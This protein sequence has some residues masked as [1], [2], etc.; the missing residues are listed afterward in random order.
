ML[1]Q[2]SRNPSPHCHIRNNMS[3]RFI[4]P[5]KHESKKWFI[6]DGI[7]SSF[8]RT[9]SCAQDW[10]E[11]QEWINNHAGYKFGW[12]SYAAGN[13][14][15]GVQLEADNRDSFP[16]L[17]FF[18]PKNLI[19]TDGQSWHVIS[20]QI[21]DQ[22]TEC[23]DL[24]SA[25]QEETIQLSPEISREDYL[26]AVV[27]LKKHIQQGDIYEVNFCQIF[28]A[29]KTINHP[30]NLWKRLYNLTEA[31]H[32]VYAQYKQWHLLSASPERYI[33]KR[34]S[35]VFSQPIKGTIRRGQSTAEDEKL[36]NDIYK[37][38]K[39]RSENV[40]IVDL[41]R[42]DMSHFAQKGTV[43]VDELFGVHTFKTVHHLVSTISC[44]VSQKVSFTDI[45]MASFPMGSMT[46]APKRS[47]MQLIR[48]FEKSSRGLYSGS[49][50]Y[51]TPEGDFD[52]N[53]VIRSIL[54]DSNLPKVSAGVGS[55]ITA[56][57]IPE[58]EYEECLLKAD[59]LFKALSSQR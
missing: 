31:P 48:Q 5:S 11:L 21:D 36:K 4:L 45:V 3:A 33:A 26:D 9:I 19:Q 42:N 16:Q 50:G 2:K 8:T 1:W 40:M 29:N 20:G 25:E 6:A 32:A 49:V 46:G 30:L 52:F 12:I 56:A 55:A 23:M 54:Y 58:F 51:I 53:V 35:H 13:E 47:A 28:S 41:V 7:L 57:C 44:E 37:S 14:L 22:L 59:A 15:K 17:F 34:N 43:K 10:S 38:E 18:V 27:Q 39:E 24:R